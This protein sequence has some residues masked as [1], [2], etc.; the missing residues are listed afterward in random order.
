MDK[1]DFIHQW[2]DG[3]VS[4]ESVEIIRLLILAI[5]F[6]LIAYLFLVIS[7]A[8]LLNTVGKLVKKSKTNIDD[9]FFEKRTFNW[10]VQFIP[11]LVI[12]FS[13]DYIFMDFPTWIPTVHKLV[14]AFI[15]FSFIAVIITVLN[16]FK[17]ILAGMSYFKDKPVNSY[18]QLVKIFAYAFGAIWVISIILEKSPLYFFSALGA[19]S[20]VL[21][22]IFKDSILGFV[23]SI[24]IAANDLLRVGDWVTV[25]K[26]GADGDVID[27]SLAS[28]LIKNFDHTTTSVPT[29]AFVSD[30]FKNWRGMAESDGRRIKRS[31]K[32]DQNSVK[33]LK[34][35]DIDKLKDIGLIKDYLEKKQE[36]IAEYQHG[37]INRRQLTNLGTFRK[38]LEHYLL[39]HPDI[40]VNLTCMV[41]QLEPTPQGLPLEIYCFSKDKAWVT[42]ENLSSDIFDHIIAVTPYFGL[43]LFQSPS[44]NDFRELGAKV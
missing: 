11:A 26:Y 2:L 29:Y 40:N 39:N 38:Y 24:Q 6:A 32:I 20:A 23:A 5:G 35:E 21:L 1:Q 14:N 44:G 17:D 31:I 22:L 33:Y 15:A 4:S 3:R 18:I 27:I 9:I 34:I 36:E 30:S 42:Y 8:L 12:Y 7:R 13:T 43:K 37:N 28:V 19:L 16:S 10:I 41:R 25:Q